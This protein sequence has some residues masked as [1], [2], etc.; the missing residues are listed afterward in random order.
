MYAESAAAPP[1]PSGSSMSGPPPGVAVARVSA[2]ILAVLYLAVIALP[3]FWLARAFRAR[4]ERRRQDRAL[5]QEL[6]PQAEG[7]AAAACPAAPRSFCCSCEV[8]HVVSFFL[9]F[10]FLFHFHVHKRIKRTKHRMPANHGKRG[11]ACA[12]PSARSV[13]LLSFPPPPCTSLHVL[14]LHF[15]HQPTAT[16]NLNRPPER[17][18]SAVPGHVPAV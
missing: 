3:V 9:L 1:E 10:F 11:F 6:L 5:V 17:L 12:S 13:C 15:N 16:T 8:C 18:F 7:P 14:P 4:C 2:A